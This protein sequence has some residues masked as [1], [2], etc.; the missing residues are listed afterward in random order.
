MS[1]LN[2]PSAQEL[3][4]F[5]KSVERRAFKRAVYAVRMTREF[6]LMDLACQISCAGIKLA[7]FLADKSSK[8]FQNTH[9][10]TRQ[11][12]VRTTMCVIFLDNMYVRAHVL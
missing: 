7:G 11:E 4:D 1:D 6:A 5:L 2:P 3:N 8:A 12:Y 9:M 10:L